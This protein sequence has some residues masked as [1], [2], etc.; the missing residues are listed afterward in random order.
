MA[1]S[2]LVQ[3]NRKIADGVVKG[4]QKVEDGV[5]YGYQKIESG[6]VHGFTKMTDQFV[7]RFLT[8]EGESVQEAKARL[9][10]EQAAREAKAAVYRNR[11]PHKGET[12]SSTKAW[13]RR[14][15]QSHRG[16]RVEAFSSHFCAP[17]FKSCG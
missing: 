16:L 5:I 8:R 1:E 13:K 7:E 6:V 3:A 11:E 12:P 2:K 4:Y 17:G 15:F 10:A 9:A 14:F